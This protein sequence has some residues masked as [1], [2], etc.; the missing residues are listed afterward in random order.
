MGIDLTPNNSPIIDSIDRIGPELIGKQI[1]IDGV[2]VS[3]RKGIS[4]KTGTPYLNGIFK[5]I[6][7]E[8]SVSTF[9]KNHYDEFYNLW[10][11]GNKLSLEGELKPPRNNN[12]FDFTFTTALETK[13]ITS[14][15][16]K[17]LEK[18]PE[19][20]ETNKNNSSQVI[21]DFTISNNETT[22]T[23]NLRQIVECA[24]Q[25]SGTSPLRIYF[26]YSEEKNGDN[27]N[28][29]ARKNKNK[30]EFR[31]IRVK[32]CD[33]LKLE[34]DKIDSVVKIYNKV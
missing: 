15:E 22:N 20:I 3:S 5:L 13:E 11:S 14:E 24:K 12:R 26:S 2:L 9:G 23:T 6:G 18:I 31:N 25:F 16:N 30:V 28:I 33:E 7:G 27:I 10:V 32:Y 8:I 19:I 21:V 17:P 1:K 34:L 4:Q 29:S